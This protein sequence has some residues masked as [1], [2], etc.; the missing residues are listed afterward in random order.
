MDA[1][2]FVPIQ[3]AFFGRSEFRINNYYLKMNH[4]NRTFP[5]DFQV[6]IDNIYFTNEE[7]EYEFLNVQPNLKEDDYIDVFKERDT[8]IVDM[9][10][11]I[12]INIPKEHYERFLLVNKK[13]HEGII[14]ELS[15][16]STL[17]IMDELSKP[18]VSY[19]F[20]GVS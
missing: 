17:L 16:S 7:G 2:D 5:K 1:K 11:T 13:H 8:Y 19:I 6:I 14:F 12:R 4:P 9:G 18:A 10:V 20:S 3:A 15:V